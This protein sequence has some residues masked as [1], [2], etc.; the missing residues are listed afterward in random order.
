[1][2][3]YIRHS[4]FHLARLLYVRPETFWTYYVCIQW[5]SVNLTMCMKI[6][7]W[8]ETICCV[9]M[10]ARTVTPRIWRLTLVIRCLVDR[11]GKESQ[12]P[13]ILCHQTQPHYFF[14]LAFVNNFVYNL[15]QNP[16]QLKIRMRDV[17]VKVTHN[18]LQTVWTE[19]EYRL[20]NFLATRSAHIKVYLT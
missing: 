2:A 15:K 10:G 19:F 9:H 7:L 17:V 11:L 6:V 12:T 13:G 4:I 18:M 16:H 8:T 14:Q 20:G 3:L 1:M 5:L